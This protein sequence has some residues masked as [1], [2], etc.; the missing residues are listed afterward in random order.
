MRK[1]LIMLMV[2]SC[3]PAHA[4]TTA[5]SATATVVQ[6]LEFKDCKIEGKKIICENLI[7][8]KVKEGIVCQAR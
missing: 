6:P 5:G 2:A 7:C 4:A 3:S 8:E 1:V